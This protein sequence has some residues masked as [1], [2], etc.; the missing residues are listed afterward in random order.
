MLGTIVNSL[1]VIIGSLLGVTLKNGI[2]KEYQNT[3]MDGIGLAVVLIGVSGGIQSENIVL[4]VVSLAIGGLIGEILDIDARLDRLGNKAQKVFGK[5][6]S[7]FSKAFVNATL[8]Y[9]IGAMA[10]VGAL[11]SGLTG[12]HETLFAKSA[13][14]GISSIIFASA[15]GIG[16][17]FSAIAIFIYQGS[18]TLLASYIKDILTAEVINEMSAVGGVLIIAIG[19]NLLNIKR[20]KVANMLPAI[21]IPLVYFFVTNLVGKVI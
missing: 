4:V 2:K 3:I 16:T 19:L 6:D 13:L 5:G 1:V 17:A 15:M 9:C 21:F 11:E 14:D 18:I 20:I 8:I 7:N 10:I 12:N